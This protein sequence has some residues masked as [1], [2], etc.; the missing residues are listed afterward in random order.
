MLP[1]RPVITNE[2]H[3]IPYPTVQSAVGWYGNIANE[4]PPGDAED[5]VLTERSCIHDAEHVGFPP[6]QFLSLCSLCHHG[7]IYLFYGADIPK[8]DIVAGSRA[9]HYMYSS[10]GTAEFEH[11][12]LPE[13]KFR[14]N[15]PYMPPRPCSPDK[16]TADPLMFCLCALLCHGKL[17]RQLPAAGQ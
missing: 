5:L 3:P 15:V 9:P 4:A 14:R 17:P 11:F 13:L 6:L 1:H 2:S 12:C 16:I 8:L 10:R 7:L